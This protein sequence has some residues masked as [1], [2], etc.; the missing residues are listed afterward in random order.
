MLLLVQTRCKNT[1]FREGLYQLVTVM[2][3]CSPTVPFRDKLVD[4]LAA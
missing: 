1:G 3:N 2:S 4:F